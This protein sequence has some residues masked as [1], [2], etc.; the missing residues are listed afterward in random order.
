VAKSRQVKQPHQR[1]NPEGKK[2]PRQSAPKDDGIRWSFSRLDRGHHKWC[3]SV[4]TSV[5]IADALRKLGEFE[6][7]NLHGLAA[8]GSHAIS[9]EDLG[10]EARKRL[11]D[12]KLDDVDELYSFRVNGKPRVFAI[13]SEMLMR[14]LWW[15]AD[16]EVCPAVKKHT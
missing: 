15:D 7:F 9:V 11:K 16:H 8:Q 5:D 14:I 13:R 6:Q 1:F 2:E 12:L 3:F 10:H 4:A